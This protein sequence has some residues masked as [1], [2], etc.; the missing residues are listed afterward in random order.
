MSSCAAATDA[1]VAHYLI[2]VFCGR[3]LAGE[4]VPGGDELAARFVPVDDIDDVDRYRLTDGAAAFIHR[5]WAQL[6][7]ARR[8][9]RLNRGG[10]RSCGP[11]PCR[12]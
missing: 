7:A 10:R 9:G 5:A 11:G 2:A 1:L 4:P 3:W 6:Q 8:T 12:R